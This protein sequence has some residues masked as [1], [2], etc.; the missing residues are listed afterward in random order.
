M[1]AI[2]SRVILLALCATSAMAADDQSYSGSWKGRGTKPEGDPIQFTVDGAGTIIG[3]AELSFGKCKV[4]GQITQ[5]D[6]ATG[7]LT[8]KIAF[9]GTE[10]PFVDMRLSRPGDGGTRIRISGTTSLEFELN[11]SG[12]GVTS[13]VKKSTDGSK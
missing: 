1:H 3:S 12:G 9:D 5:V 7:K 11:V 6:E 4:G 2:L 8:G 10:F 13:A